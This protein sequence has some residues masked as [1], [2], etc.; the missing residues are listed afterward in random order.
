M[1]TAD[2]FGISGPYFADNA[3]PPMEWDCG[4]D[5]RRPVTQAWVSLAYK[6]MH[7]ARLLQNAINR[8]MTESYEQL[9]AR[10][11][12]E[13]PSGDSRLK[14]NLYPPISPDELVNA[15]GYEI[16]DRI[17]ATQNA[18]VYGRTTDC[19]WIKVK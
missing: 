2:E 13:V 18:G 10:E 16:F 9:I 5:T 11:E 6:R 8:L 15:S 4:T 19:R 17:V 3:S 7:K 12:K 14:D 1:I